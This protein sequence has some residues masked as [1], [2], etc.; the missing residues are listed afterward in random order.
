[1]RIKALVCEVLFRETCACAAQAKT[2]IDLTFLRR[3]LHSNPDELRAALQQLIDDTDETQEEAVV[4]GYGLCS[5]ALAGLRPAACRSSS[6]A[7]TITSPSCSAPKR[8]MTGSF[9]PGPAPTTTAAGGSNAAPTPCP[10]TRNGAGLDIAFEE[11]V[12]K[13]GQDN[14]DYLWSLQQTWMDHYTHATYIDI[15]LGDLVSYRAYTRRV[16]EEHG[17]AMDEAPGKLDLLQALLDGEWDDAR[18]LESRPD[19]R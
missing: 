3:G 19:M 4:F 17:W 11:L 13:Y 14:A 15:P 1:M 6:P 2:V 8:P 9:P 12:E 5:N 16:A 7:P 18:F 10:A